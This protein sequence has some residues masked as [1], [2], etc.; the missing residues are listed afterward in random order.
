MIEGSGEVHRG[1]LG[2]VGSGHGRRRWGRGGD[3]R[4]EVRGEGAQR[5]KTPGF[6]TVHCKEAVVTG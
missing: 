2:V 3:G 6:I 1:L 5:K 4:G